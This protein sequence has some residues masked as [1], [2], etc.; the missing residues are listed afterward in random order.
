MFYVQLVGS[1]Q[2]GARVD[3]EDDLTKSPADETATS[4]RNPRDIQI[5]GCS[6]AARTE[7]TVIVVSPKRHYSK[8]RPAI[9]LMRCY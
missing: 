1:M 2:F 9:T 5:S 7:P 8:I 4:F 6:D 3:S